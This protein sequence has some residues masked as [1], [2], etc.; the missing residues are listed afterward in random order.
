MSKANSSWAR[1][2]VLVIFLL[3]TALFL[4]SRNK[5]E[6]LPP[7]QSLQSF[8]IILGDNFGQE[9]QMTKEELDVLGDGEFMHRV[10]RSQAAPPIDF[11]IAF[12]PTQRTGSTIHSPQN[13]LPGAGWTPVESGRISI[14]GPNG[15]SLSVNRYIMA[16]G[17]DREMVLY[18]YQ[19]QGRVV[20]SEY[21]SKFYLVEDSIRSHRS[22][23]ALVRVITFLNRGEATDVAQARAVDFAEQALPHLDSYIPR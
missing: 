19:S 8:P 4:H 10:Y 5:P 12:F 23:G 18:W 22:D 3:S 17:L 13:C 15:S 16:K 1:F 11:F 14:P 2:A 20:A 6:Q 7:H 21:W 9:V